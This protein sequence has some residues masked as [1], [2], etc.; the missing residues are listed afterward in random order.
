MTPDSARTRARTINVP[1]VSLTQAEA[2]L[3]LATSEME[4]A[5]TSLNSSLEPS[6]SARSLVS[7]KKRANELVVAQEEEIKR[8]EEMTKKE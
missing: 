1:S 6:G 8:A 4:V 2:A 7:R 5:A 3:K